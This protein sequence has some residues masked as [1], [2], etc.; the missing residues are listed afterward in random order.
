MNKL[1]HCHAMYY[2][3]IFGRTVLCYGTVVGFLV[4]LSVCSAGVLWPNGL[5]DQDATCYGDR[6]RPRR[7]CVRWRPTEWDTLFGPCLLWRNDR[8][9]QLL[10]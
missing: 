10:L 5:K 9:S 1:H 4:C 8:P 2:W 7:H 6:P 3:W